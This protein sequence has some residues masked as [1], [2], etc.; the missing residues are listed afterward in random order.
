MQ[1]F[2]LWCSILSSLSRVVVFLFCVR[3]GNC[4]K[5]VLTNRHFRNWELYSSRLHTESYNTPHWSDRQTGF[6]RI[7]DMMCVCVFQFVPD[8]SCV[9][10]KLYNCDIRVVLFISLA[11]IGNHV[12]ICL[13]QFAFSYLQT[14]ILTTIQLCRRQDNWVPYS[15]IQPVGG[16]LATEVTVGVKVKAGY[17]GRCGI[18]LNN[19]VYQQTG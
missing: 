19:C 4:R 12:I 14:I 17:W 15:S 13:N 16:I 1:H 6:P 18:G 3:S 8:I 7:S 2:K 11:R 9:F 5:W 10:L